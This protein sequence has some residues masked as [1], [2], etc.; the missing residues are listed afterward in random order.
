MLKLFSIP[1]QIGQQ[2][3]FNLLNVLF[4]ALR[5]LRL[6]GKKFAQYLNQKRKNVNQAL[7]SLRLRGKNPH[8]KILL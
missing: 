2:V 1:A 8:S 3:F 6:C 7:R 5:S 4:I